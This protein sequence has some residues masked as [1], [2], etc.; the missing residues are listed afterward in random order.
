MTVARD[1][2][3]AAFFDGTARGELLLRTCADGHWSE[4]DVGC[5]TT[6]STPELSWSAASGTGRVVSWS[7]VHGRPRADGT[8]SRRVVAVVELDEGPWWWTAYEGDGDPVQ[9]L[10]VRVAFRPADGPDTEA[11]PYVVD[12]RGP[13]AA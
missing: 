13:G 3:T 6:C 1:A 5:C 2:A 11:V 4:P 12:A 10:P 8:A 9:D 7:V